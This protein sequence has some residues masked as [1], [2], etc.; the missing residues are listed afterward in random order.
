LEV[1]VDDHKATILNLEALSPKV[2]NEYQLEDVS[3]WYFE[4]DPKSTYNQILLVDENTEEV[5]QTVD[6]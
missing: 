1:K 5:V 4:K 2:V 6:L 3:L